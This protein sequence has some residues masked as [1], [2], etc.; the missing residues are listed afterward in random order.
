MEEP[1]DLAALAA[2]GPEDR[3]GEA[4]AAL[5]DAATQDPRRPERAIAG[6]LL[7]VPPTLRSPRSSPNTH[8]AERPEI[9]QGWVKALTKHFA[10]GS[11][12]DG[13]VSVLTGA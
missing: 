1:P 8:R 13:A 7:R 11:R 5:V 9:L 6:F 4:L 10:E 3:S 2:E 12:H